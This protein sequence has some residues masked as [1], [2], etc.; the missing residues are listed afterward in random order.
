MKTPLHSEACSTV[1]GRGLL[2]HS[3]RAFTLIELLVVIAIIAI[4]AAMLLPAL[5]KA[6]NKAQAIRCTSNLK[7]IGLAMKMYANDFSSAYPTH[8]GW[9]DVGGNGP[10][11]PAP[12]YSAN[13]PATNRPLYRYASNVEVFRCPSDKGDSYYPGV[14]KNCYDSYGTSYLVQWSSSAFGVQKVTDV[15]GG[16]PI[17]ESEISR[18]PTTKVI[19]GDWIWHPNRPLNTPEAI[20][21]N[22]KGERRLNMLYGDGHVEVSQ[23]PVTLNASQPVNINYTW[24]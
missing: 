1:A 17:K 18:R 6:K 7:Q 15:L 10:I 14:I 8:R 11:T 13:T 3:V 20:W 24:W 21:H 19:M 12:Y 5:S 16:K 9:A 23:L 2:R 4:L 22:F